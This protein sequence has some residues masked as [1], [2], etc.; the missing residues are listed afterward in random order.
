MI[1]RSDVLKGGKR[2]RRRKGE[3]EGLCDPDVD[4]AHI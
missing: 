2:R 1:G 4:H 3:I